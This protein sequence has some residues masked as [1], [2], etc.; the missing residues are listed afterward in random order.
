MVGRWI[1]SVGALLASV[2]A[3]AASALLLR[4][5]VDLPK[6]RLVVSKATTHVVTPLRAD[7]TVEYAAHY[8]PRHDTLGDWREAGE[9]A[10]HAQGELSL[11]RNETAAERCANS[12]DVHALS[13]LI[14]ANEVALTSLEKASSGDWP[15]TA[16]WMQARVQMLARRSAPPSPMDSVMRSSSALRALACRC[17]LEAASASSRAAGTI[18]ELARLGA[19]ALRARDAAFASIANFCAREARRCAELV[20]PESARETLRA[21]TLPER[22]EPPDLTPWFLEQHRLRLLDV[23]V[24]TFY[25]APNDWKVDINV[26]LARLNAAFDDAAAHGGVF[27]A[28]YRTSIAD[29][30]RLEWNPFTSPN[31]VRQ[32]R[33]RMLA[34]VL[35]ATESPGIEHVLKRSPGRIEDENVLRRLVRSAQSE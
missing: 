23:T 22:A 9:R 7:G 11:G 18:G 29:V 5:C 26:V 25:R 20:P 33:S 24:Q 16:P 14:A 3:L 4:R 13:L 15:E 30:R 32:A 31:A 21:I 34:D 17:G 8:A 12:D 35:A 27:A 1:L 10:V 2:T 19:S 6:P 28:A